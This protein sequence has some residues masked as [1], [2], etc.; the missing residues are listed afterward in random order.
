[1]TMLAMATKMDTNIT[2][3][4]LTNQIITEYDNAIKQLENT[5]ITA[6]KNFPEIQT[7][8]NYSGLIQKNQKSLQTVLLNES[9]KK[10]AKEDAKMTAENNAAKENTK[11][12]KQVT[13]Q[14][15]R[16]TASALKQKQAEPVT[17]EQ[18]N[19]TELESKVSKHNAPLQ[20]SS[21]TS[22]PIIGEQLEDYKNAV[23]D[24]RVELQQQSSSLYPPVNANTDFLVR[25]EQNLKRYQEAYGK[26]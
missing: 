13:E 10:T 24:L 1:M 3:N 16:K 6:L 23:L 26:Q 14:E 9:Q 20:L 17:Q 12:A 21:N 25:S 19:V 7:N 18:K 5:Y 4:T 15:L 11:V 8:N 2:N 22:L